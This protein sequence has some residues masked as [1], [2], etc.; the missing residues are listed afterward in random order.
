MAAIT[1]SSATAGTAGTTEGWTG[2]DRFAVELY[3]AIRDGRGNRVFS[4]A[5]VAL[6]LAMVHAGARE[7]TAREIAD[8]L[9]TFRDRSS[10][11]IKITIKP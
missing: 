5:S 9:A 3:H 4:P 6:S 1:A 8:A 7:E 2:L 10:G 11:A